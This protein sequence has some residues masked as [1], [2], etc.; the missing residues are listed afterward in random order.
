VYYV[1]VAENAH[2]LADGVGVAD[3]GQEFIAEA[4]TFGSTLHNAGNVHEG[5]CGGH[6]AL[7]IKHFL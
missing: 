2:Y 1:G 4:F 5:H 7:C 6:D 3:I